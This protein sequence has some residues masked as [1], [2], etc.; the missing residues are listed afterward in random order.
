REGRAATAQ[1]PAER[2]EQVVLEP[3]IRPDVRPVAERRID[4][5]A[6]AV[7]ARPRQRVVAVVALAP[8][9]VDGAWIESQQNVH[10]LARPVAEL[11]DLVGELERL[12]KMTRGG[13]RP[14][15]DDQ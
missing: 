4:D 6:T 3:A 11:I 9:G 8:R 5:A 12:R 10:V 1:G 15:L 2:A 7:G 14:V 13:V